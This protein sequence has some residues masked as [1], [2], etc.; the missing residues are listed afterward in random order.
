[1]TVLVTGAT[2][3]TG[4]PLV[5]LLLRKGVPV[6]AMVR[7]EAAAARFAGT[8]VTPVGDWRGDRP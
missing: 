3:N 4:G 1:M 7:S 5:D 8:P 2:G 6:R